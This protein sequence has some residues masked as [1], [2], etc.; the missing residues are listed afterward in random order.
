MAAAKHPKAARAFARTNAL[1]TS[2]RTILNDCRRKGPG[3]VCDAERWPLRKFLLRNCCHR[4]PKK[5]SRRD[6]LRSL[7]GRESS[8]TEWPNSWEEGQSV[9]ITLGRYFSIHRVLSSMRKLCV[10]G[11]R[12]LV[13]P[14]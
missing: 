11:A 9:L 14:W 5:N 7:G 8:G 4:F 12:A 6:L 13:M 10:G 2:A 1:V 3:I